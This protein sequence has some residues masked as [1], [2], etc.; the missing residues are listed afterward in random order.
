MDS[1][2]PWPGL[3]SFTEAQQAQFYGRDAEITELLRRVQR[4]PLTLLFGQSGL[5]KTSLLQAGL[6]PRLREQGFAPVLLRI[7]YGAQAPAAEAQILAALGWGTGEGLWEQLHRRERTGPIRLLVFDQFEEIFTLGQGSAVAAGLCCLLADLVENRPPAALEARLERE[8]G[9]F[10]RYDLGRADY[11]VLIGL[12]E[13]Y[14][15]QLETLKVQMPSI[16]QNRMRLEPLSGAQAMAAVLGPGAGL[17]DEVAAEAIVRFVAGGAELEAAQVEPALLSLILRELNE[18]RIADGAERISPE[19]LAGSHQ[20]ILSEFY[21]RSL[22]DQPAAV[23][24]FIEDQLLT[25][26]GHRESV[27][28]ERVLQ[29]FG[30]V[31]VLNELVARRLLRI[32]ERLQQRRV[33]L[34]HDV[35]CAVVQGSREG[36]RER[37]ALVKAEQLA[38]HQRNRLQAARV[39]TRRARW[40][41]AGASLLALSALA[42]SAIA[43][44]NTRRAERAE[45]LAERA[46][47]AT[48]AVMAYI[49]EDFQQELQPL[50]RMDLVRQLG[51]RTLA[52]YEDLPLELRT[53]DTQLFHALAL[54]RQ[55]ELRVGASEFGPAE[56]LLEQG[57]ALWHALP[58]DLQAGESAALVQACG[59]QARS[60]LIYRRRGNADADQALRHIDRAE[61][62][63]HPWT[64]GQSAGTRSRLAYAHALAWKAYVL[65][66]PARFEEA[67][68]AVQRGLATLDGLG[69]SAAQQQQGAALA[70]DMHATA[71][72]AELGLGRW[73][74]LDAVIARSE[75]AAKRHLELHPHSATIRRYGA[76]LQLVQTVGLHAFGAVDRALTLGRQAEAE[77][78]LQVQASPGVTRTWSL[79]GQVQALIG[80]L[81]L[82]RGELREAERWIG[83]G[84]QSLE[85]PRQD[86]NTLDNLH[87][88][89][90][91]QLR[92]AGDRGDLGAVR[93][94]IQALQQA[95]QA[96]RSL[97]TEV[98]RELRSRFEAGLHEGEIL[99]GN[100]AAGGHPPEPGRCADAT[101]YGPDQAVC[102]TN[103]GMAGLR[104][105]LAR[106]DAV[107]AELRAREALVWVGRR[108][109]LWMMYGEEGA[110][111][112][113]LA[114]LHRTHAL[115]LLRLGRDDEARAA[116]QRADEVLKHFL[117]L[118]RETARLSWEL[119]EAD[120]LKARLQPKL[121]AHYLQRAAQRLQAIPPELLSTRWVQTWQRWLAAI[122]RTVR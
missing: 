49:V 116:A 24:E 115:A 83:L 23:R 52:H 69:G 121:R 86:A 58:S 14:L 10:E 46:R 50:E 8:E 122:D 57:F 43:V 62:V 15:A 119:V 105:A 101:I 40:L 37:Q 18:Q 25:D 111:P 68:E 73:Q 88:F 27:A 47:H 78:Q 56:R 77:M 31:E 82:E 117:P 16:T 36:R 87:D 110:K 84:V 5:G 51:E 89:I 79:L 44:W 54:F 71:I 55:A 109:P 76:E 65:R 41:A 95:Q 12:R 107:Q 34:T 21:E 60:R 30:G 80:R 99:A 92:L 72:E 91:L 39:E 7:D 53:P 13:D 120:L 114:M 17:I 2:R 22:A 66:G 103:L 11:R 42:A 35:L 4:R 59:L 64:Q 6:L 1:H 93:A 32:E 3:A 104:T 20:A 118:V 38:S 19:Q 61:Q 70:L 106:D 26:S 94:R 81:H 100:L 96:A 113:Y 108:S 102:Q 9:L 33:E 28:E 74:A 29:V 67:I 97:S 75:V 63:L 112:R 48:Q 90:H 45:A 85:R 98:T